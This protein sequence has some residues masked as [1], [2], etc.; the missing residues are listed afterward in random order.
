MHN[1]FQEKNQMSKNGPESYG[2][3]GLKESIIAPLNQCIAQQSLLRTEV[4]HRFH[5]ITYP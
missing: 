1:R 2:E 4:I 5:F 3:E